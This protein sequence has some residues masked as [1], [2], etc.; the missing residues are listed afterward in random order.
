MGQRESGNKEDRRESTGKRVEGRACGQRIEAAVQPHSN[1][2]SIHPLG[3][4][5]LIQFLLGPSSGG[6]TLPAGIFLQA[7]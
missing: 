2:Q 6:Q 4:F 7:T 1:P 3:H 5:T